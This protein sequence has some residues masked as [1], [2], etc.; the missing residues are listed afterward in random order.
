M[1]GTAHFRAH[2]LVSELTQSSL[3]GKGVA[4]VNRTLAGSR[5]ITYEMQAVAGHGPALLQLSKIQG[6]ANGK[7]ETSRGRNKSLQECMQA[8]RERRRKRDIRVKRES[9]N[10]LYRKEKRTFEVG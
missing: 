9:L 5:R 6:A 10:L 7:V 2:Q 4:G 3:E 8:L 1:Y